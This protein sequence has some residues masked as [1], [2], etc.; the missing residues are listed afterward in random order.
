MKNKNKLALTLTAE[1]LVVATGALLQYIQLTNITNAPN[2]L[3]FALY[4]NI[5]PLGA[6]IAATGIF[7]LA[8]TVG[9]QP[10]KK[11]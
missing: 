10:I 11:P 5:K 8:F 3:L 9:K 2:W 6:V 7:A 4:S 1:I